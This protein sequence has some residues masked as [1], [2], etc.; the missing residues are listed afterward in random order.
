VAVGDYNGDGRD[1]ILWR[2]TNGQLSDWLGTATGGFVTN[3]A[4]AL[5][6]AA[7]TNWHV[8]PEPFIL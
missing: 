5:T 8:Q 1:D 2:N 6:N 3:D 7:P 4:N